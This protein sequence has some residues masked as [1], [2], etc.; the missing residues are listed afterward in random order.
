MSE[1]HANRVVFKSR[2]V[3]EPP[4]CTA[5]MSPGAGPGPH[6]DAGQWDSASAPS[7]K[8]RLSVLSSRPEVKGQDKLIKVRPFRRLASRRREKE[9]GGA[10]E[11]EAERREWDI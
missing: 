2:L 10:G 1:L 8:P 4:I 11:G 6:S 3:P 5:N 7:P 9:G